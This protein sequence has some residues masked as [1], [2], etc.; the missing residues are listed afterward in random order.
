MSDQPKTPISQEID[1]PEGQVPMISQLD[2]EQLL[3]L[4]NHEFAET[5]QVPEHAQISFVQRDGRTIDFTDDVRIRFQ[6]MGTP[7][8]PVAGS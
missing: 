5:E 8:F 1:L 3:W 4:L 2:R 7:D 6:W